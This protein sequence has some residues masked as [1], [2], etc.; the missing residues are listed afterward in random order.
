MTGVLVPPGPE[1]WVTDERV[2][3]WAVRPGHIAA[4]VLYDGPDVE[5]ARS[6]GHWL[7][8]AGWQAWIER[9]GR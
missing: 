5:S 1:S 7:A 4:E 9:E 6:L 2:I 3:L 8:R